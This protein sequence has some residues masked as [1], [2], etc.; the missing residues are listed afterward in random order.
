METNLN[1]IVRKVIFEMDF[2]FTIGSNAFPVSSVR[3]RQVTEDSNI[4]AVVENQWPVSYQ[5][6]YERLAC[7]AVVQESLF[8]GAMAAFVHEKRLQQ[9]DE[10]AVHKNAS[11]IRVACNLCRRFIAA[12][13]NAPDAIVGC[14]GLHCRKEGV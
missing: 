8:L 1:L 11:G 4:R 6:A 7:H 13:E 9:G 14:R 3:F 10:L 2:A 12:I 5:A